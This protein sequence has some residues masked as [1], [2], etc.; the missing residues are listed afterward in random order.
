[1]A[2]KV[3]LLGAVVELGELTGCEL[4]FCR[5]ILALAKERENGK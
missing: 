4:P 3:L 1:M 5:A 2:Y